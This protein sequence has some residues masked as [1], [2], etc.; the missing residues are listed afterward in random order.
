MPSV[1]LHRR[2]QIHSQQQADCWT[3]SADSAAL[4][5]DS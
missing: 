2:V 1:L 3:D 5:L 4:I